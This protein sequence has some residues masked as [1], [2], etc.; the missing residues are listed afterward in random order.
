MAYYLTLRPGLS[1]PRLV[2]HHSTTSTIKTGSS[3]LGMWIFSRPRS[4]FS[5]AM[6]AAVIHLFKLCLEAFALA[7]R[8]TFDHGAGPINIA[9]LDSY[10][11]L[12]LALGRCDAGARAAGPAA[13]SSDG[14]TAAFWRPVSPPRDSSY[15]V[16]PQYR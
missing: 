9:V 8:P 14:F 6:F 2:A 5:S 4:D 12:T 7:S 15:R 1:P 13:R 3:L 11:H 16:L 10:H